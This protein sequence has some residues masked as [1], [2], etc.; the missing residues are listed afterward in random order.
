M[1]FN[2]EAGYLEKIDLRAAVRFFPADA[3]NVVLFLFEFVQTPPPDVLA[4]YKITSS[5]IGPYVYMNA[6]SQAGEVQQTVLLPHAALKRIG[7]RSWNYHDPILLQNLSI[8][9]YGAQLSSEYSISDRVFLNDFEDFSK[10][11]RPPILGL[12]LMAQGVDCNASCHAICQHW[13]ET[14]DDVA[15]RSRHSKDVGRVNCFLRLE[16][17]EQIPVTVFNGTPAMLRIPDSHASYLEKIGDKA[18]NMIRKAQRQGYAYRKVD[19]DDYLD[20]VLA[21]R[22][23]NPER[24]G[25]PIP[26]YYKVRPTRMF[27]EPFRNGCEHHGEGFFGVFKDGRLVAYTTI[28]FYGELGQVNHILGHAD[29]LQEGVMNLLVSEMVG[30]IIAHRPW[31]RA[32]NYLYPHAGNTNAGIGLFKR[33]I[34]FMPERVV[35]TQNKRDLSPYFSNPDDQH[36]AK[37]TEPPSE[38][39][40]MRA[41]TSKAVKASSTHDFLHMPLAKNRMLALDLALQQLNQNNPGIKLL[42]YKEASEPK[43]SDFT[44]Q[45]AHLI[46]LQD[47]P[48]SGLQEF[49]SAGLKGLRKVLPKESILVFEF[50]RVIDRDYVEKVSA[51]SRWFPWT[52]NEKNRRINHNLMDYFQK[53]FKSVD[54]SVDDVRTGFKGSDYVVAGLADYETKA[55]PN[56]FDCWLILRKI[57]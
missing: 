10:L 27:D 55:Q 50:K 56:G 21:I 52:L 51:L 49:L 31:V 42:K 12:S 2:V 4:E 57:R 54:L 35:V 44:A 46:V 34:G 40:V 14:M 39:K 13:F 5:G 41:T 43:E 32:I 53:R 26:E 30:D 20:D 38:K 24:Q 36:P 6:P 33:S 23:S 29:H 19:P 45:S 47:I 48:F 18:R 1:W 11:A 7:V 8:K 37:S 9:A 25:K 22:T 16:D 15:R 28:F 17:S 3:N